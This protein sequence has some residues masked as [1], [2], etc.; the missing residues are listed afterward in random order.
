VPG[1]AD[2]DDVSPSAVA[3]ADDPAPPASEED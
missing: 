1:A 2:P 3:A